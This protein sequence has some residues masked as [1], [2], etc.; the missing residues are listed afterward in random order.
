MFGVIPKN[1]QLNKWH[2]IVDLSHPVGHSINDVIT[3]DL[4]SLTYITVDSAVRRIQQLGQ[5]TLLANI[6]IKSIF[7]LLL[8]HL[9]DRHLLAM[10]WNQHIYIDTCLRFGL[11]SVP[12]LFNVLADLLSWILKQAQ[13]LLVL[14]YLDD[15]LTIGPPE[16][17]VCVNNLNV[18]K[19]VCYNLGIPL[20]LEK[21]KEPTFV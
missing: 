11:R 5:G 1:H 20:A 16:S 8:V 21:V 17:P 10:N 12:K 4:C 6:D 15:F 18:I 9:A 2:L 14:H 3:K 19:D 7:R 13:V